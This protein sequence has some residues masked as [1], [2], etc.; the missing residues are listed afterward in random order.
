MAWGGA[1]PIDHHV[2]NG[3]AALA[4]TIAYLFAKHQGT[5]GS[6]RITADLRA[7]GWRVSENT[8]ATLMAEQ[9]LTARRTRKRRG[10]PVHLGITPP[11]EATSSFT[12][13]RRIHVGGDHL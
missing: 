1:G 12:S 13:K 7:Q 11:R 8:V 10:I 3:R 9:G 5:Y 6:P 4:A 2:G